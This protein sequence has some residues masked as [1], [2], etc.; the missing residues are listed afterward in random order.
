MQLVAFSTVP[1]SISRVLVG[2]LAVYALLATVVA[3]YVF[4][5]RRTSGSG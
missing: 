5:A 2:F 4:G 1:W 3:L